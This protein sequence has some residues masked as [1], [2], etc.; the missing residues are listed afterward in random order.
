ML[1]DLF[2][3]LTRVL[4][5]FNVFGYLTLRA[6]LA[7]LTALTISFLVGPAMIRKLAAQKIGQAVRDD[8]RGRTSARPARRRWAAR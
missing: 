3:W 2:D 4:R 1:L 8:G 6:V 7:A 5:G